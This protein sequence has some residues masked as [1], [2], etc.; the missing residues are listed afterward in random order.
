MF[1]LLINPRPH[2]DESLSGYLQR[3]A[4]ANGLTGID[5]LKAFKQADDSDVNEWIHHVD[6]PRSWSEAAVELRSPITRPFKIWSVRSTRFCA[7][8]LVEGGYWREAWEI[9]LV[10]SCTSHRTELLDCCPHC[11]AKTCRNSMLDNRCK[12]CGLPL[13]GHG[14]EECTRFASEPCQ[15]LSSALEKAFYSPPL[16]DAG[17]LSG[18]PFNDLHELAARFAVRRTRAQT[19]MQLKVPDMS[20]MSVP[21]TLADAAGRILM[22]WPTAFRKFLGDLKHNHSSSGEW[23]VTSA[24]G[25]I[26]RD[27]HHSLSAPCFSFV[28]D[29]FESY[30]LDE[31][32]APLSN[33]NRYLSHQG[34]SRAAVVNLCLRGL[35]D[36]REEKRGSRLLRVVHL[37]QLQE[38]SYHRHAAVTLNGASKILGLSMTRVRQLLSAGLL[39]FFGDHQVGRS[40]WLVARDSLDELMPDVVDL[41]AESGLVTISFIAKH[42]LPAGGGLVELLQAI[43]SGALQAY[44]SDE[45]ESA[46]LGQ[47]LVNSADLSLWM[48][49]RFRGSDLKF[50]GLSVPQAAVILGVKEEVAYACVRLG[51]L[52]SNPAK[53]GRCTQHR[54]TP[55][56]I[57]TFRQRYILGPEI[58]AYLGM[59]PRD[60]LRLLWDIR[61]R[62]VAGPTMVNASCRQ[63][64]WSR[65]KK[66]IDYLVWRTTHGSDPDAAQAS[67]HA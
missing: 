4:R 28:R 53:I 21:R 40:P 25:P 1:G 2:H 3:L 67:V 44:R 5:A 26:Y 29:E 7:Q 22:E 10:T 58:A 55:K 49:E 56:A 27:I 32:A 35:I 59:S 31:W 15:W 30:L 60:S 46:A 11:S 42:Y 37:G 52:K 64:V 63:Y 66:L 41:V 47:L 51:L 33:R 12:A 8:C 50:S 57:E 16:S 18:L 36:H 61:F 62:P 13:G 48:E 54:V 17:G 65:S 20:S 14:P 24:F 38:V 34:L 23:K 9:T 39:E 19:L 6:T 45:D 43:K